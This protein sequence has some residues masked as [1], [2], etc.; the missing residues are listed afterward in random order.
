MS[1]PAPLDNVIWLAKLGEYVRPRAYDV[2]RMLMV[3]AL[4]DREGMHVSIPE[5]M[6]VAMNTEEERFRSFAERYIIERAQS[7]A[8]GE[9]REAAWKALLDA[10]SA[11]MQI[12]GMAEATFAQNKNPQV[13]VAAAPPANP[14]TGRQVPKYKSAGP[15]VT[16]GMALHALKATETAPRKGAL[17][18][19]KAAALRLSADRWD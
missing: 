11:Y 7:F 2:V 4:P 8:I 1:S 19:L 12:R 13:G 17:A 14:C 5:D 10:K 9:E 18:K 16:Q 6:F 15:A 3:C